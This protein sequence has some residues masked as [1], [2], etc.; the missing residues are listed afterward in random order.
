[1]LRGLPVVPCFP[2]QL[3][4]FALL[5]VT[6]VMPLL[7]TRSHQLGVLCGAVAH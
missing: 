4:A 2:Y 7:T 5:F 1:M 6:V 3:L